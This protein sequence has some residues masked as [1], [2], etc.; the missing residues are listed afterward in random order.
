MR[1]TSRNLSQQQDAELR[2]LQ[3]DLLEQLTK[4][5]SPYEGYDSDFDLLETVNVAV[6]ATS[7]HGTPLATIWEDVIKPNVG[8]TFLMETNSPQV[9]QMEKLSMK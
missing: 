3:E 7:H 2:S 8:V 9:Y 5:H 6:Q 4:H 1:P